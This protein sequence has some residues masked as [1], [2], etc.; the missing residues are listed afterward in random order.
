MAGVSVLKPQYGPT[1]PELFGRLPRAARVAAVVVVVLLAAAALTTALRAR[2]A[3]TAVII[4]GPATF[5]LVYGPRLERVAK[6]PALLALRRERPDGLFLDSYI[7]RSL[8][9]PAY[10][11]NVGGVLP[12]FASGYLKRIRGRYASSLLAAEGR[13]RVNNAV[14]YEVVLKAKRRERTIYVRHLLLVPEEPEGARRGV[15][16][17]IEST[18]SA[19]TPNAL[20]AGDAGPLKTALRSFRF[21]TSRS[22]GER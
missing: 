18:S 22:G 21:G 1:L 6:T 3:E 15:A 7:V 12:A 9:L 13:T 17:E 11:G 16:I 2:S 5:N 19:G 10:R 14:G 20:E 4:R 8:A